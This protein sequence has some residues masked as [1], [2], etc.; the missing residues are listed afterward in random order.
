[1]PSQSISWQY[2]ASSGN[3]QPKGFIYCSTGTPGNYGYVGVSSTC[4]DTYAY[5]YFETYVY[6]SCLNT[7]TVPDFTFDGRRGT[8][9]DEVLVNMGDN[10]YNCGAQVTQSPEFA[11]CVRVIGASSGTVYH[12]EYRFLDN[13]YM[14][15][16]G[17]VVNVSEDGVYIRVYIPNKRSDEINYIGLGPLDTSVT[18]TTST[19]VPSSTTTIN[20][21][22]TL[23][24]GGVTYNYKTGTSLTVKTTASGGCPRTYTY[25]NIVTQNGSSVG[26]STSSE[27]TFTLS[28]CTFGHP[29]IVTGYVSNSA[30]DS[31]KTIYNVLLGSAPESL[32]LNNSVVYLAPGTQTKLIVS[33]KTYANDI[34]VSISATTANVVNYSVT[35]KTVDTNTGSFS[36]EITLTGVFTNPSTYLNISVTDFYGTTA[37]PQCYIEGGVESS[38]TVSPR[39]PLVSETVV[40]TNTSITG[41]GISYTWLINN[42]DPLTDND[43]W[44]AY[45]SGNN[46][47]ATFRRGATYSISLKTQYLTQFEDTFVLDIDVGKTVNASEPSARYKVLIRNKDNYDSVLIGRS[48][49]VPNNGK[50][51]FSNLKFAA[52]ENESSQASFRLIG[53]NTLI[54]VSYANLIRQGSKVFIVDDNVVVWSG[55]ITDVSETNTKSPF[56]TDAG[57]IK[58]HDIVCMDAL[59]ELMYEQYEGDTQTVTDTVRNLL[60]GTSSYDGILPDNSAGILGYEAQGVEE[61]TQSVSYP[62]TSTDRYSLLTHLISLVSWNYRTR[63]NVIE[64]KTPCTVNGNVVTY[65]SSNNVQDGDMIYVDVGGYQDGLYHRG[66]LFGVFTNDIITTNKSFTFNVGSVNNP[67]GKTNGYVTVVRMQSLYDIAPSFYQN[68]YVRRYTVDKDIN[69]VSNSASVN[70]KYGIVSVTTRSLQGT[71]ITS[72][73]KGFMKINPDYS[74]PSAYVVVKSID[75]YVTS[76]RAFTP[77]DPDTDVEFGVGHLYLKG[78]SIPTDLTTMNT[79]D[80]SFVWYPNYSPTTA[81]YEDFPKVSS[82]AGGMITAVTRYLGTD[83]E[84][85][86]D[87]SIQE[88]YDRRGGVPSDQTTWLSTRDFELGQF[89]MGKRYTLNTT[90]GLAAGDHMLLGDEHVVINTI[91]GNDIVVTR[92][93]SDLGGAHGHL[94]GTLAFKVTSSLSPTERDIEDDSPMDLY[95]NTIYTMIAANGQTQMEIELIAQNLLRFG[96]NYM[97]NGSATIPLIYFGKTDRGMFSPFN[98]GDHL[99]IQPAYTDPNART[100][101]ELVGYEIDTQKYVAS[102]TY[103]MPTKTMA[104]ILRGV[105]TNQMVTIANADYM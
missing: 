86:T 100:E 80:P 5:T 104:D 68:E 59:Y 4:Y 79:Y 76:Y 62:F 64:A 75:T 55:I 42:T 26:S 102:V 29:Y 90:E 87:L 88:V 13:I 1:M 82:P 23:S 72:Q 14:T 18:Y 9:C 25:H 49:L 50:C 27:A 39:Y 12:E 58:Y 97:D 15:I 84:K 101:F 33:G 8:F 22:N 94:V 60:V 11:A 56:S 31:A 38:F 36:V 83:N 37:A 93:Q 70:D 91:S 103:G 47:I 63:P 16:R 46:L 96:S 30:G 71:T 98:V 54:G 105:S 40:F 7:I 2:G 3:T 57:F 85:Y 21:T 95:G 78:W 48:V 52:I 77:L 89:I 73:M 32:I 61:L 92:Y 34:S 81:I 28:K 69:N 65:S 44:T 53:A 17:G 66:T 24:V 51:V 10:L 20:T 99:S 41:T 35:R 67:L 43:N 19:S 6:A 74:I 45:Y